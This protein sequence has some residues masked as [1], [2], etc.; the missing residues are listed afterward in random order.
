MPKAPPEFPAARG[1]RSRRLHLG[2]LLVALGALPLIWALF[3]PRGVPVQVQRKTWRLEVEVEKRV[4]ESGFDW[5]DEMPAGAAGVTRRLLADPQGLRTAPSEHCRYTVAQWRKRWVAR[6]EGEAPAP[7]RWPS[8]GLSALPADQ[9]GAE[10]LGAREAFYEVL[11]AAADGRSW[12]C[13]L[14]PARWQALA[15][16]SRMRVQVNRQ[17]VADCASLQAH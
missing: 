10:R 4:L 9:L 12:T 5:C 11:L 7:P 3:G 6:A 14:S 17:D 13:R 1:W 15:P 2:L 16:G 8:P